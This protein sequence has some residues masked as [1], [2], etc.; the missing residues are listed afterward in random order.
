M[1]DLPESRTAEHSSEGVRSSDLEVGWSGGVTAAGGIE[2][3]GAKSG[4]KGW[5]T[6]LAA[7]EMINLCK[8]L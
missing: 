8:Q 1:A 7:I 3:A 6:A 4:N 5:E 2:R